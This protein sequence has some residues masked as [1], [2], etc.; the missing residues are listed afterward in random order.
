MVPCPQIIFEGF[1]PVMSVPLGLAL[2]TSV[3]WF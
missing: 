3:A 2:W 1:F